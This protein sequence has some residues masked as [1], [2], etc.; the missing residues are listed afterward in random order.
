MKKIFLMIL[1][2]LML[3]ACDSKENK[4]SKTSTTEEGFTTETNEN[5]K[6]EFALTMDNYWYF[7]DA[8]QTQTGSNNTTLVYTFEGVLSFA[9]YDHVVFHIDYDIVGRGQP[10]DFHYPTTT[11]KADIEVKL[12]AGGNGGVSLPQDYVPENAIPSI[13]ENTLSGFYR[14]LTIKSVSGTVRFSI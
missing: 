7:I 5:K 13:S 9:Y 12:N 8:F 3:T 2:L 6:Y 10:G 11:H 14:T 1:P 4:T